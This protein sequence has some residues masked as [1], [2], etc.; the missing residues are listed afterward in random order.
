MT[1]A[2]PRLEDEVAAAG[3]A[4]GL[5]RPTEGDYEIDL[6]FF[7]APAEHVARV[8][9]DPTQRD[10]L[11]QAVDGLL[12]PGTP[13]SLNGTGRRYHPILRS[14]SIGEL[15]LTVLRSGDPAAPTTDVGLAGE[16]NVPG[17]GPTLTVDVPVV[18]ATGPDVTPVA[19]SPEAPVKVDLRVPFGPAGGALTASLR[20]VAPPNEEQTRFVVRLALVGA[21]GRPLPPIELDPI[22]EPAGIAEI[23]A[24]LIQ[25]AFAALA[26]TGPAELQPL[27]RNLPGLLGFGPGLPPFPF[28]RIASD[29]GALRDW[30]RA[31]TETT[32]DDGRPALVAWLD[33]LG[34]LLGVSP[35][36]PRFTLPTEADP[37]VLRLLAGASGMPAVSLT[38]GVRTPPGTGDRLLVAGL[39]VDAGAGAIHAV[40]SGDA[41]LVAL[42]LSGTAPATLA[43]RVDLV[44]RAPDGLEP[45]LDAGD[46]VIGGVCAGLRY[47]D[48]AVV[49]VLELRD[50]TLGAAGSFPR[51][52]LTDVDAL[53]DAAKDALVN[54][55]SAGLG[56]TGDLVDAVMTLVGLEDD[57]DI[58][59]ARFASS[60]T[61][62]LADYYRALRAADGWP[63]VLGA[64]WTLLGGAPATRPP[65]RG[66]GTAADPWRLELTQFPSP[67]EA[68]VTLHLAL[69]DAA[70]AGADTPRL[71]L[72]LQAEV[73]NAADRPSPAWSI[74]AASE[75][76]GFDLPPGG[77]G[78]VRWLGQ[79]SLR[80]RV[81]ALPPAAAGDLIDVEVAEVSA[82]AAW[83]PGA[84]FSAELSVADIE[85]RGGG[86]SIDLGT[87]VLRPP[88]AVDLGAPDLGLGID[89]NQLWAALR[90]LAAR[91]ARSWL[92][93]PGETVA[94]LLGLARPAALGLPPD[95]PL[96]PLPRSGDLRSILEDP[97]G[98]LRAWLAT[99]V[100]GERGL[101]AEREPFLAGLGRLGSRTD[102]L[103]FQVGSAGAAPVELLGWLG[104]DGPPL[105]WAEPV[106]EQLDP[107]TADAATLLDAAA[108]LAP[109]LGERAAGLDRGDRSEAAAGLQAL[110]DGVEAGDGVVPEA[111]AL[112]AAAGWERGER[113]AFEAHH[114]LPRAGAVTAQ[115]R[116]RLADLTVGQAA[117]TWAVVLLAPELAG[118][119][120]WEPLLS[121]LAPDSV[122]D[123]DLRVPGTDPLLVDLSGVAAASHYVVHLADDGTPPLVAVAA[124][125][126]LVVNRI[127]ELKPGARVA[128]VGHSTAGVVAQQQVA[129]HPE[130][131]LGLVTIGAPLAPVAVPALGDTLVADAVR[132]T[133][134]LAPEG[135][136]E[137]GLDAAIDHL[138]AALDGL[139]GGGGNAPVAYPAA[140]FLRAPEPHPDLH[141]V[142]A[143][144]LAGTVGARLVP[145]LA[146]A[147][148]GAVGLAGGGPVGHVGNA[149]RV[150]VAL[151]EAQPGDP[152]VRAGVRLDLGR[153]ALAGD[154][155]PPEP[156]RL[157]FEVT[158][159]D[160]D[161]WLL[162]GPGD[163]TPLDA[164][165]RSVELELAV[166]LRDGALAAEFDARLRDAAL[167]GVGAP[168]VS[169]R[170]SNGPE[171]LGR[172]IE[173]LDARV[174]PDGQ[175]GAIVGLLADLDLVHRG[176]QGAVVDMVA[177]GTLA[178]DPAAYLKGRLPALLDRSAGLLG[179]VRDPDAPPGEGPW[180]LALD[181]LP[182]EVVI[183][184]VPWRVT[185]RAAGD[186]IPLLGGL[187]ATV[188]ATLGI[189]DLAV[190]VDAGLRFGGLAVER[191][192]ATGRVALTSG[193]LDEP[194]V[195]APAD[196]DAVLAQLGALVPRLAADVALT[197]V[198][199]RLYGGQVAIGS[200]SG[201]F[202]DPA[203]WLL[204]PEALGDGTLPSAT[205]VNTLLS[206]LARAGGLTSA[207]DRPL[208]LPGDLV[209]AAED[210][211]GDEK[212]PARALLRLGTA[213]P[214]P[215]ATTPEGD[216]TLELSATAEVDATRHVTPGGELTLTVPLPGGWDAIEIRAGYGAGGL[217]LSVTPQNP[218]T[219]TF[220]LLPRVAGLPELIDE[221]V[222]R[223]LPEALDELAN[224]LRAQRPPPAVLGDVLAVAQALDLYDP[225]AA[226]TDGTGFRARQ[227]K[228]ATFVD[229]LVSGGLAAAAP[230]AATAATTLLRRLLGA[231]YVPQPPTPTSIAVQLPALGGTIQL[232][233]DLGVSPPSVRL[234]ALDLSPSPFARAGVVVEYAHPN[235]T[236]SASVR[237]HLDTD[238]GL[239]LTPRLDLS[240]GAT[241]I[242]AALRPLGNDEIVIPLAPEPSAPTPE[243]LLLLAER[244]LV[245]LAAGVVLRAARPW[246]EQPLWRGTQTTAKSVL[247]AADLVTDELRLKQV[248]LP[249]PARL[250]TSV[251]SGL[252]TVEIP[253]PGG[254]ALAVA[255]DGPRYGLRLRGALP[256]PV[257]D[258]QVV[259]QIGM[260]LEY[261]SPWGD[262]GRGL[263]VFVLDATNP[264][265]PQPDAVVRL[266]GLGATIARRDG[267]PLLDLDVF[268]LGSAGVHVQT[269]VDLLGADAPRR[270]TPVRTAVA[271]NDLNLS[272]QG[273]G[274]GPPTLAGDAL[275][276][277]S[278]A[279]FDMDASY[280]RRDEGGDQLS[281]IALKH[282]HVDDKVV[283][284]T[285]DEPRINHWLERLAPELA[286][287]SSP[288]THELS[289]RIL[290]GRPLQ[291][292]RFDWE[293]EGDA[294]TFKLPGV[295]VSTPDDVRVTLMLGAGGKGLDHLSLALTYD[296]AGTG[297]E[298]H[299]TFAWGR[300]GDRELQQDGAAA[301]D[302][303]AQPLFSL[304]AAVKPPSPP[305][306]PR[307]A[308]L[309]LVAWDIGDLGLPQFMR[310]L[311][312][313][314]GDL[315]YDDPAA[316][317]QPTP[318]DARS[319]TKDAWDVDV[320]IN[321]ALFE[322]PF[323]R[324]DESGAEQFIEIYR[325]EGKSVE[326]DWTE[327]TIA[328]PI[329]LTVKLGD[330]RLATAADVKFNWETMALAVDH[331]H[332]LELHSEHEVLPTSGS[333]EFLGLRWRLRGARI[334]TGPNKDRFHFFT[335]VTQNSNYRIEQAPGCVFEVE[336]G[337]ISEEPIVFAISDFAV[338]AGGLNVTA[339]VTDR[340]ARLNG[341]DT[342]FRF[343]GTRLE[344]VESRI[345]AFTLHGTGPL[346]PDLVGE[347]TADIALQ[348]G[349]VDGGLRLREG[350]AAI[351]GNKLLD[352]RGTRF[353]FS[354]DKLGL[355]FVYDGGFHLYFLVTGTAEF[356]PA[357]SDD[358]NGPLALLGG[359]KLDLVDA[360]LTGD[361]SVIARHISFL[362]T[363]PKPK[364]FSFLGAFS[365][366]LRGIG[367]VPQ[368]EVFEGDAAMMLTGQLKFAQGPGDTPDARTDVHTLYLGLPKPG[369]FVPRIHFK[370]LPVHLNLGDAF[371]LNG[372]VEFLDTPREKG[373]TGDGVLEIQGLP[374]IAASFAFLRV[375]RDESSPWVRAWFIYLEVRKVS[376]QIPYVQLYL[377][378]VGLGFGYRY[379]LAAIAASDRTSD[380]RKLLQDLKT[381]SRTQGDLSKRDRWSVD[382]E[383][384]GQ[385][386]RWTVALRAMISQTSASASPLRYEQAAESQLACTFLLDAVIALRSDLTFLMAVRGWL[387]ANYH[388][389]VTDAGGIR[390]RPMLSG[391]VLL[392]P[393]QK[394]LLANV[395]TNPNGK[396]GRH[397][398]LPELVEKALAGVQVSATLLIEPGLLHFEL[399]WPNQLR[400][401]AKLGPLDAEMR[402]GFI[403]RVS[404]TEMVLGVSYMARAQLQVKAGLDLGIVG[405]R[406]EAFARLA[407]GARFLAVLAFT[408][409]ANRSAMYGALGIDIQI[410]ISIELWIRIKLWFATI[411][412]TFRLSA[413]IAFTAGIEAGLVGASL[414]AIG[415]RGSGTLAMSAM[416]RSFRVSVK[417]GINEGAVQTALN[418]TKPFL[419]V[420]L[421]AGDVEGVPGVE[422]RAAPTAPALAPIGGGQQLGAGL[423]AF[424]TPA[425]HAPDYDAFVVRG[426]DAGGW[427]YF[428]LMPQGE[429]GAGAA[430]E[431]EPGFLPVPPAGDADVQGDFELRLTKAAGED[432]EVQHYDALA[433]DWPGQSHHW[434]AGG[435]LDLSWKV[436]WDAVVTEITHHDTGNGDAPTEPAVLQL[437]EYLRHAFLTTGETTEDVT[438]IGDPE[439]LGGAD[440]LEDPRVQNPDDAAVEAAIRGAVEQFRGSPLFKHDPQLE[441]DQLLEQAFRDDTTVYD[442][443]G[444]VPAGDTEVEQMQQRQQALELRDVIVQDLVQDLREYA[445]AAGRDG[446]PAPPADSVA[447]QMGLVFRVRGPKLPA[448][449]ERVVDGDAAPALRQRVGPDATA[450]AEGARPVRTFN[451]AA[452]DFARVP[453]RFERVQVLTDA[454]TIAFAW[455]L[456]WDPAPTGLRT[457]AQADPDHHLMHYHVR[458]RPLGSDE[459]EVVYT[460]KDAG[461]LHREEPQ[462]GEP[463]VLRRLKPRFRIVD[464][465]TEET[466]DDAAALP[467]DGRSY[468]YTITARDFSGHAGR[469]LTLVATRYPNQPPQVPADAE[470]AVRYRLR[471]DALDQSAPAEPRIVAPESVAV[472]W[473]EP[474]APTEGPAVGIDS[475][476]LVLR[477]SATMPIGSYGLDANTQGP[478][479]KRLP[480]TNARPLP[481]DVRIKLDPRDERTEGGDGGH[482]RVADMALDD[483]RA[484]GVLP[485]GADA[486]WRPESWRAFLQ[487][488]SLNGVPSP[489]APVQLLLEALPAARVARADQY[490]RREQRR[491]AEL[492]WLARPIRFEVLPPEDGRATPG[493]AHVPMPAPSA[494]RF[495]G[496]LSGVGFTRHP[497]GLRCIRLRWNQAP[498][499]AGAYPLDLSAGFDVLELD[500]DAHTTET[501]GDAEALREALRQVQDVRMVPAEDLLLTPGDT[502]ATSQWEAWYPSVSQR[503]SIGSS[504]A[505]S[506]NP[507]SPWHSWRES[508]LDWPDWPGVTDVG[509][510]RASALHPFLVALVQK[511]EA[512]PADG[513]PPAFAVDVQGSPPL[514]PG[515]LGA[516]LRSTAP[517]ADPYGWGVLQR[518]GLSTCVSLRTGAT[519]ELVSGQAL[520]DAVNGAIKALVADDEHA[521]H[522]RHLHVELLF[523]PDRNVS[524]EPAAAP[525][526]ALLG[527]VQLSLRPVP[528]QER[529]YRRVEIAGPPGARI[530]LIC[531]LYGAARRC[532][533]VN[534][535]DRSTIE[536]E[537]PA[538]G[539]ADPVRARRAVQLGTDGRATLLLRSRSAISEDVEIGL[540][541]SAAPTGTVPSGFVEHRSAPDQLVVV[542]SLAEM[543]DS[544]RD[545][546]A[547]VLAD[548]DKPLA[549]LKVAKPEFFPLTADLA[550]WFSVPPDLG[551]ELAAQIAAGGAGSAG[552]QWLRLKRYAEAL[553]STDPDVPDSERIAVPETAANVER[554]LPD[555]L[556]WSQRFFDACGGATFDGPGRGAV[557]GA[558]PWQATAYPRVGSPAYVAPDAGG[559]L[560]YDHLLEDQWAHA[561][562]YYVRPYGRYEL[563]WQS[564][565][566]SPAL[567]PS[568]EAVPPAAPDPAAG[569]LDVVLDRT[570]PVDAPLVLASTR[571]DPP[572]PPGTPTVPGPTWEVIVA[573][574]PEQALRERNSTLARQLTFRQVAF[575]LLRRFAYRNWPAALAQMAD[576]DH[577]VE[578]DLVE[579]RYP[580]PPA[581]FPD[582]PAEVVVEGPIDEHVA[583]SL[584]LPE[585]LPAFGQGALVL[586]W[587]GLPFFYEH[588]LLLVAQTDSTVSAVN[589]VDQRDFE[590]RSPPPRAQA[591][592]EVMPWRPPPPFGA[593][594]TPLDVHARRMRIEL[595]RLWDALPP[596]AR[597]R[598]AD[599]APDPLGAEKATRRPSSLPDPD[600][601]YQL[602]EVFSGNV[603]VQCELYYDAGL[604]RYAVRQLGQR[605]LADVR[606]LVAPPASAPQRHYALDLAVQQVSEETLSGALDLDDVPE[607]TRRKVAVDGALLRVAG[608]LTATDR[609]NLLNAVDDAD[610]A[611]VHR[612]YDAWFVTEPVNEPPAALP[613]EL[614]GLVDFPEATDCHLVWSGPVSAAQREQLRALPGDRV[615]HDALERLADAAAGAADGDVLREAVA[616]GPEQAPQALAGWLRFDRDVLGN[617]VVMRWTGPLYDDDLAALRGWARLPE[618]ADAVDALEWDFETD[619]TAVAI[620]AGATLPATVPALLRDQLE[621]APQRIGWRGR[622]RSA[623]QRAA[624]EALAGDAN[625]AAG[626]DG[627]V[628]ALTTGERPVPM[629]LPG[630]PRADQLPR[631]LRE[632]LTIGRALARYHGLMTGDEARALR[633]AFE[634]T[635]DRLAA[636]RLNAASLAHGMRGR[637]LMVRALRGSAEP[638]PLTPIQRTAL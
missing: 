477:K 41:V 601:V 562:R 103:A 139:A 228:L 230:G 191:D 120:C 209:L 290:L 293:M 71:R 192:G 299:S 321:P 383:A 287:A 223:L 604:E 181:P 185:V 146:R 2:L 434:G 518:F 237:G 616:P 568:V 423:A 385:D 535:V 511:L 82:S 509:P 605:L 208:A 633:G 426:A 127:R 267:K 632:R 345:K 424:T 566:M 84:P 98:A 505:G 319:L 335:L 603:E 242:Q 584:D 263:A 67:P 463:G 575:A 585:R 80:A 421:E 364:S 376:F 90:L 362:I 396:L 310:E 483:L 178:G 449:L 131:A 542:R 32:A 572:A 565:R 525:A 88:F 270:L 256:V 546:L 547:A 591:A 298:A 37:V 436:D 359:I 405:V 624:L 628:A 162:G 602:V 159:G 292:V 621:L 206:L 581:A 454:T 638:S 114:L 478:R 160:P 235:L 399:G 406:V 260:P 33:H 561:Y 327:H 328:L 220:E 558:G 20:L 23:A 348:F 354:V 588:R 68:R 145:E 365:M 12:P 356:V 302:P 408:D 275:V 176:D 141:G 464:H 66:T 523:R 280:L 283:A 1:A 187:R 31:L 40:V 576:G 515:D 252:T 465:F 599:E 64:L 619:A 249:P 374:T 143:L 303:E 122:E 138:G 338:S 277:F 582:V 255:R 418:R 513:G 594:S 216:L 554:V 46:V 35:L 474:I 413:Q 597:E 190:E 72:G 589:E 430:T 422:E 24:L 232:S 170:D 586:Q 238:T 89:A 634:E 152:E 467:A 544:E 466:T 49:P 446:S 76:L 195:L 456:V 517:A 600:V 25:A 514:Q 234:S 397:P 503:R 59:L 387:S 333:G 257:G 468:L 635:P 211:P 407:Y 587:E 69:W 543:N 625:F 284:A 56:T 240:A 315:P 83:R 496:R 199:E 251:L 151:P 533:V 557:P 637:R 140:A 414:N 112:P 606:G 226:A 301:A 219:V 596:S 297:L 48:E 482:D 204:R 47:R 179:V 110:A 368:A 63:R 521:P 485:D 13:V 363:L 266:G 358:A 367:F 578:L 300:D 614:D 101:S 471:K 121:L 425:F 416:G 17:G 233:G 99:L 563:L 27:A 95:F 217:E 519:G 173:A 313:P 28:D 351:K 316:L 551:A 342:R 329:G 555:V 469:P 158:V 81:S 309:V 393:R 553:N 447:F 133:E 106:V 36:A 166:F 484:E 530:D 102:P 262:Q 410:R 318:F 123:V 497:A 155:T 259:F 569:A 113:L 390:E 627:L 495:D 52:D 164:R 182:A 552:G 560:T 403:F 229:D 320:E 22:G 85:V 579:D 480:T 504:A 391:F 271:M 372:S 126:E 402:G 188:D 135:L 528:V 279:T 201:L 580:A 451:V 516:F 58:D 620:P 154:A 276:A 608:V 221:A 57:A 108:E 307:E 590:Y 7:S 125:L 16:V 212:A 167:L 636:E 75:L 144:A 14:S 289:L 435:R 282:L 288:T 261:G 269:D 623:E 165:V 498:S 265:E 92:G 460:V 222:T 499:G 395:S 610:A 336:Y 381:I 161:G 529:F 613:A 567:F 472:T 556:G 419:N 132:L 532:T 339:E 324:R 200:V 30:L 55:I 129:D 507:L 400:W 11:L 490:L 43:E 294:R 392:S 193:W 548:P 253:L 373:F 54:A 388:D 183:E 409:P 524:L 609:G 45:L 559:R 175:A 169:L 344:I 349:Q 104:P 541:L 227:E 157:V 210:V 142:L 487:T 250:L 286:D 42:P 534:Q 593:G 137:P 330:M 171:L 124:Q 231:Q 617:Y 97:L 607:P 73:E 428:V 341:I 626:R 86:E 493:P 570:R 486:R 450:P 538:G 149:I 411:Q 295:D 458:R 172:L 461:A 420:G 346:P 317:A 91:A 453:P 340:P 236:A 531:N 78:A 384:P 618:L 65:L 96:L 612:L 536:I 506:L 494:L 355:N 312:A 147:V 218:G 296:N 94:A 134:R 389:Y 87:L 473:T 273:E 353:R 202:T 39:R 51:L 379:T 314:L 18:S 492:E 213:A 455:D 60:P 347:A 306:Q 380:V 239:I 53:S 500:A 21:D 311:P 34:Q 549:R 378:E 452:T 8:L 225:T 117:A 305:A 174:M 246:L 291:E 508:R 186:G 476:Y 254:L 334:Q 571:L 79:Q 156:P 442:D 501:V 105:E 203:G 382:L 443:R 475:Y 214:L 115:V 111:A 248:P 479:T 415:V 215:L 136:A 502:L 331:S 150:P 196:P 595:A 70:P 350:H 394:R 109:Y 50:V 264:A 38:A 545:S 285:W 337:E 440:P 611:A 207:A 481:T 168:V 360:P 61:R 325:P 357:R 429:R 3:V 130:T 438:P 631:A 417:F 459:Q 322:L 540:A 26:A 326:F 128:L 457:D 441:Y 489:L 629:R 439:P 583:R 180:R 93:P 194:V 258:Q 62:A 470:L 527:I 437:R 116:D 343:S 5:L 448:W 268:Q 177:L 323:L 153:L 431:P 622:L 241:G 512:A 522:L 550:A 107:D 100:D 432:Y 444:E 184:R 445:E 401:G 369:S 462:N 526:G 598:W 74:A 118:D 630:R 15:Y 615:F 243:Q 592:G 281:L 247:V 244:W 163:G 537:P 371:R 205:R 4:F 9:S 577:T 573:Q 19:A 574:H 488:E 6:D 564:L 491:P 412:K 332:G 274:G 375:R 148:T 44:A 224:G 308:T 198:L 539:A 10:A 427:S 245:P 398:P 386:P 520:L 304:S 366:E 197:A 272:L 361:M 278:G 77:G 352:C 433:G 404:R 29:A 189:E 370:D 510:S 377:R 119:D